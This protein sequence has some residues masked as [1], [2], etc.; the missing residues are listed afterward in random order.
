M[1]PLSWSAKDFMLAIVV[2]C[3]AAVLAMSVWWLS[4]T[5]TGELEPWDSESWYYLGG[6]FAA[7]FLA[8]LLRPKVFLAAPLGVFVGQILFLNYFYDP[9]TASF[10]PL[11]FV[12]AFVYSVAALGGAVTAALIAWISGMSLGAVRFVARVG[13]RKDNATS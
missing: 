12:F 11:G 7:G 5:I 2:V 9:P 6:L 13:K 3:A 8:T 10:L 4:P 1:S